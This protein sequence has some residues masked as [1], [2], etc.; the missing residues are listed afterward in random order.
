MAAA[1]KGLPTDRTYGFNPVSNVFRVAENVL[2]GK[3]AAARNDAKAAIDSLKK[4][5]AAEDALNYDEPEDWYIPVKES[6]GA[7]LIRSGEHAEAEKVFRAELE[8]HRRNGRALFGL[9]ERLRA[10]GKA[11]AAEFVRREYEEA[12]KNADIK[13]RI[14]DM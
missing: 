2:N 4:A 13:L 14:E 7:A 11:Q 12:W 10:Q 6:L 9:L 5:A 3:I 1:V 8:K